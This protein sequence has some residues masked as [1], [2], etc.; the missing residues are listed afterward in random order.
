MGKAI[1][2]ALALLTI[3]T[4]S[5]VGAAS[6]S[7]EYHG[8]TECKID[9]PSVF[10]GGGGCFAICFGQNGVV[11]VDTNGVFTLSVA[12][13]DD[14]FSPMAGR[15]CQDNDADGLYCGDGDL[16]Q[17]FCGGTHVSSVWSG[18]QWDPQRTA[19]VFVAG[20]VTQLQQCGVPGFGTHGY[21]TVESH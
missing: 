14:V 18:G 21:V 16:D 13:Q 4:F 17:P 2:T 20:P 6:T 1:A 19:V 12:I 3:L 7:I 9:A 15:V 11:C 8:H 5:P 10:G